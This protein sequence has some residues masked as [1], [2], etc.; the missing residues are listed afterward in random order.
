[1]QCWEDFLKKQENEVGKEIVDKWLRSLK[2]LHFDACNLYLEARDAFHLTWFEEHIRSKL[3]SSFFNNN[4]RKIQVHVTVKNHLEPQKVSKKG[5]LPL[6]ESVLFQE[7]SLDP[8]FRI[9][10]FINS[11]KNQLSYGFLSE[12]IEQVKKDKDAVKK[13]AFNPIYLY[14]N[15]GCGKTHLLMSL[16]H[17]F[18]ELGLKSFYIRAE[19]FTQHVISAIRSGQMEEFRK[20]YRHI[21]IL[22][23]DDIHHFAKKTAT[24]EEFFH[25][26][27]ALHI[28]GRQVILSSNRSP[29]FLEEIEPRLISR[30]EWGILLPLQKLS[31]EELKNYLLQRSELL[32]FP[33]SWDVIDFLVQNFSRN[34]KVLQRAL[35]ALILRYTIEQNQSHHL[36]LP[37]SLSEAVLFLNELLEEEK[38]YL[39][40]P[41]KIIHLVSEF[42]G[43]QV[44]DILGKAQNQE[45]SLPRQVAISLCRQKLQT[46]LLKLGSIFSRDHST[47]LSSIKQIDKK[48]KAG[49][50]ELEKALQELLH[51]IEKT[52]EMNPS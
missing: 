6:K 10:N 29:N 3:K 34:L 1:M 41:Q 25:T 44:S 30:F 18:K 50:R 9:E 11:E 42:Y 28:D 24:Q 51:R 52:Q 7:D 47:I 33:L 37:L 14:G 17:I 35:D 46:P 45:Y 38:K 8:H 32:D 12:F 16:S 23:V 5:K 48:L 15:S 20:T 27:N 26:F 13:A 40:S 21:D 2:I 43:I 36:S 22:L 31:G 19:S 49:D 4:H 39:L